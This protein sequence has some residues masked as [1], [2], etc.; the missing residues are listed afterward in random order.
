MIKGS[1]SGSN[2]IKISSL[3]FC[4]RTYQ[5]HKCYFISHSRSICGLLA[6]QIVTPIAYLYDIP[7]RELDKITHVSLE[8]SRTVPVAVI[9]EGLI[10]SH[11]TRQLEK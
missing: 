4:G 9:N 2:I 7:G 11:D 5:T 1:I 8:F 3:L 10:V 6:C